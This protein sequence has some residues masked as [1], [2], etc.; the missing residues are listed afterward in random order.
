ML[1][2]QE[3]IQMNIILASKS[4]R[5]K[6]IL[7][8]LGISFTIVTADTDEQSTQTDPALLVEQLALQ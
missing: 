4:P 7:E 3:Y 8:T 6:E 2:F 1:I 5:R